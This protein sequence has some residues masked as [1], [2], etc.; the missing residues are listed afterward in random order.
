MPMATNRTLA[1]LRDQLE[2][3][4][5]VHPRWHGLMLAE[6]EAKNVPGLRDLFDEA[7]AVVSDHRRYM[8]LWKVLAQA[9]HEHDTTA[10]L[11]PVTDTVLPP[12]VAGPRPIRAVEGKEG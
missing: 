3:F 8:D 1:D 2:A 6:I 9:E 4:K 12:Y 11:P 5:T 7:P 10:I